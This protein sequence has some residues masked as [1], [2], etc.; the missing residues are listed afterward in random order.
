MLNLLTAH[1]LEQT[2]VY[3]GLTL[4]QNLIIL[5]EILDFLYIMR[6]SAVHQAHEV[7]LMC[8][9][10]VLSKNIQDIKVFPMKFSFF[11]SA[12]NL[13]ILNG[14]DFIMTDVWLYSLEGCN[15]RVPT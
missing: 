4:P 7:V 15:G 8:T 3:R 2:F 10:N 6:F 1:T 9:H 12:N 11:I 5:Y 14:Q 13:C